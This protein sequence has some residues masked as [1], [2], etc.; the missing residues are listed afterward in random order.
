MKSTHPMKSRYRQKSNKPVLYIFLDC[1][2]VLNNVHTFEEQDNANISMDDPWLDIDSQCLD[3][4]STLEKLLLKTFDVRIIL[5]STWRMLPKRKESLDQI[6]QEQGLLPI[7][8]CT[9]DS[10]AFRSLEIQEYMTTH[11]IQKENV[12]IIDDEGVD[13][14]ND[15]LVKTDFFKKGLDPEA[16]QRCLELL[17]LKQ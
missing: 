2:G 5:S 7:S 6:F 13:N 8:D 4:L 15:R 3:C 17:C 12:L 10:H 1:D 16:I 14:L 9:N 11:N